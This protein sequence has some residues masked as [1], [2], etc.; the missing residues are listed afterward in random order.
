MGEAEDS[1]YARVRLIGS[2]G[3]PKKVASDTNF[4]RSHSKSELLVIAALVQ[5][6]FAPGMIPGGIGYA[7]VNLEATAL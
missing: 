3:G 2:R 7:E 4:S 5:A 6:T 1:I